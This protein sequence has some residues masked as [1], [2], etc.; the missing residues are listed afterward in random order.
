MEK[1]F[2]LEAQSPWPFAC[3]TLAGTRGTGNRIVFFVVGVLLLTQGIAQPQ[4]PALQIHWVSHPPKLED[5]LNGTPPQ[6]KQNITDFRQRDPG[7]GLPVSLQTTAYLFY[8]DKNLY[9]VFVCQ[10]EPGKSRAR[11]AKREAILG[12]DQVV[13]YL[14][15]FHD[16]QRAYIFASNP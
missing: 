4:A 14:D 16:R 1:R 12:D 3:P 9:A 8:D 5:F 10:D 2:H 15:T 11:M 6:I 13:L 7:D